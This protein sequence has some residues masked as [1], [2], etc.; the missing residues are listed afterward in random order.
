[1][2]WVGFV[3]IKIALALYVWRA[4]TLYEDMLDEAK[5][6]DEVMLDEK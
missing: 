1:M 5:S 4:Y 6:I 2:F 3:A